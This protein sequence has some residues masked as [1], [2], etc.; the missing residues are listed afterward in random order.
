[1]KP[2]VKGLCVNS[3]EIY[4][5]INSVPACFFDTFLLYLHLHVY[6]KLLCK[7]I[8]GMIYYLS[9]ASIPAFL[10]LCQLIF[11]FLFYLHQFHVPSSFFFRCFVQSGL[12]LF[13]KLAF[14]CYSSI[15]LAG[16]YSCVTPLCWTV[17]MIIW[18]DFAHSNSLSSHLSLRMAQL[19]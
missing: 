2:I 6:S 11:I 1:M 8:F 14:L 17:R 7:E 9:F 5:W 4:D 13:L 16:G 15:A 18:L 19:V 3:C 12:F 10:N